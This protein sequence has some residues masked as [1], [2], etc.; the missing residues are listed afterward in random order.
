MF[1]NLL[2]FTILLTTSFCTNN[3]TKAENNKPAAE[4]PT[5]NETPAVPTSSPSSSNI[6]AEKEEIIED[7]NARELLQLV[8]QLRKE[9]CRCGRKRMK[10]VSPLKMN[11]L[12]NRA[13]RSHANDMARNDFF[14]HRG[15]NGSSISDR[16]AQAGYNW[17]AVG[18]NIFWGRVG[19]KEVF[20]GWRD[21]PGHCKNMMSKDFREMG[22]A[23]VGIYWVQEFGKTF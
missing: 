22:F 2:L 23:K 18:E 7:E 10:P 20:E 6:E 13:A 19:I 16:I 11:R 17:Q 8:N 5:I 9:G 14:E 12:L 3:S 1:K 21:S 15:S 4:I